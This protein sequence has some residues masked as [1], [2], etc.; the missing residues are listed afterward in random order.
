M[1]LR[2]VFLLAVVPFFSVV[3]HANPQNLSI[4]VRLKSFNESVS[5]E[6]IGGRVISKVSGVGRQA[7]V[8][9][10]QGQLHFDIESQT[11]EFRYK[12][13]K[14]L[15]RKI[16]LSN[17]KSFI[18]KGES[19]RQADQPLP[20]ELG[21]FVIAD[22]VDSPVLDVVSDVELE[23]YVAGVVRKEM[24]LSWPLEA[25][26]AQAVAARSYAM[27][28]LEE[29]SHQSKRHFDID[30]TVADQVY[31]H[32]LSDKKDKADLATEQ[33][34]SMALLDPQTGKV[35]K[36]FFHADC[37]GRTARAQDVWG[38][39]SPIT[40]VTD[41]SC[42]SSRSAR[43]SYSLPERE[44]VRRLQKP[45]IGFESDWTGD[46]QL[47]RRNAFERIASVRFSKK[48]GGYWEL[49]SQDFRKLMGFS[50][51]KSTQFSAR[52]KD[53]RW[54]FVGQG[55][56]HGVGLCQWGSR[57]MA[58]QGSNYLKILGWY[59]RSVQIADINSIPEIQNRVK[60]LQVRLGRL[61]ASKDP[62]SKESD[63]SKYN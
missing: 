49:S 37:G 5:F 63:R 32:H 3:V 45:L 51:F 34:R 56:G 55:F 54:H 44:M 28:V 53:G 43:W 61:E 40:V 9:P 29:R 14:G 30:S 24:P 1:V 59:Y 58:L 42:P 15:D 33:T 48:N 10:K 22:Q 8:L 27:A 21:F 47:V 23:T 31:Q 36:S 25:L 12:S 35:L 17:L 41:K 18:V 38:V 11:F 6:V 2:L 19:I 16:E 39:D 57:S 60:N 62:K 50:N 46:I 13:L 26:K 52:Q 4:H 20:K 7:I